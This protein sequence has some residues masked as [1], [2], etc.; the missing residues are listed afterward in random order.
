MCHYTITNGTRHDGLT[1]DEHNDVSC[2][3]A[4]RTK[5]VV[6]TM[7]CWVVLVWQ[8]TCEPLYYV[9]LVCQVTWRD[10]VVGLSGLLTWLVNVAMRDRPTLS[11]VS[12]IVNA[13]GTGLEQILLC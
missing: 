4:A 13:L 2:W 8:V 7:T 1:V 12:W 10:D 5:D 11:M 9:L 3:S 6:V